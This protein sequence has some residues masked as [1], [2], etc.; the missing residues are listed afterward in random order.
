MRIDDMKKLPPLWL[1]AMPLITLVA[2]IIIVLIYMPDD[3]LSGASQL[4]L[5]VASSVCVAIS[6]LW[7]HTPWETFEE[8][9]KKTVGDA[10]ISIL[11]LLMIGVMSSTWMVSGVVPTF[12]YYGVQFM[13][14]TFFLP[15]ACI[16]SALISVMTG[17]SWTTI[18]TI[19]IALLGIGNALGIPV[20]LSAG[21][22]I[23]GAYFGDKMSPMSDTTVLASS[24]ASADLFSHIRYMMYTTVP[25]ITI[26]LLLYLFIGLGFSGTDMEITTYTD[27]LS[28]T[29][30]ITLWTMLVPLFTAVL[31]YNLKSATTRLI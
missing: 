9:I 24:M 18:A 28:G 7:C 19:G 26:S 22:I 30:N 15:C 23:S 29:F 17:T 4:A 14:P 16:I 10:A 3:A 6:M 2:L 1:S 8:G 27:G 20:A 5:I 11:I 25:S 31:I 13:S 21:A 12:I